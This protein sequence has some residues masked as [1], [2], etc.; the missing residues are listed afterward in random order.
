MPELAERY[1]LTHVL[2]EG[3]ADALAVP[4]LFF[5]DVENPPEFLIPIEADLPGAWLYAIER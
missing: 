2:V 3:R 4:E 5:F 1:Q